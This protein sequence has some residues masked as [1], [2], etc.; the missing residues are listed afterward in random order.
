MAFDSV[1]AA[2]KSLY[3]ALNLSRCSAVQQRETRNAFYAGY[4]SCFEAVVVASKNKTEK[5]A[6]KVFHALDLEL[7][8]W[9]EED[10]EVISG[11]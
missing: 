3:E 4:S 11:V 7:K 2:W 9:L 5:E 8:D 10:E 1:A 6:H